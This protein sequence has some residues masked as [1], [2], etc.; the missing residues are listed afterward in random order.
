MKSSPKY[1]PDCQSDGKRCI[2][3]YIFLLIFAHGIAQTKLPVTKMSSMECS[4]SFQELQTKATV[5]TEG[6]FFKMFLGRFFS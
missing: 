5:E 2:I 6:F 3:L 1:G 4:H